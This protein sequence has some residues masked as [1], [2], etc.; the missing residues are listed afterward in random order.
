MTSPLRRGALIAGGSA[1]AL[2]AFMFLDWFADAGQA[3]DLARRAREAAEELGL[4]GRDEGAFAPVDGWSGL[5]WLQ[6]GLVISAIVLSLIFA[7]MTFTQ[8]A[9][10]PP[11]ALSAIVTGIGVVAFLGLLYALINPPGSDTDRE[12]G[13]YLGI[14][15]SA[16]I[17]AGG[18]LGMQ[19][20]PAGTSPYPR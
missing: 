7:V 20:E 17:V 13:L 14:L 19:E 4:D 15:A 11:V 18:Y 3:A 6:V 5:G 1:L 10:S 2:F 12:V 9:V 8:A 16:G